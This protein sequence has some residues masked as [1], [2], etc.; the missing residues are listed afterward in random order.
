MP[1]YHVYIESNVPRA[2]C[3]ERDKTDLSELNEDVILPH[4]KGD[5]FHFDGYL[6][7][8]KN[9]GRIL[10]KKSDISYKEYAR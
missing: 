4:L 3:F 1:Y 10:I 2:Q 7:D 9:V 8:K 5:Q 6:L